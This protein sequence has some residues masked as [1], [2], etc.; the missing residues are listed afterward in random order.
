MCH[1]QKWQLWFSYFLSYLPFSCFNLHLC[2]LCNMNTLQNILMILGN[3]VEQGKKT[4]CI[5]EWQLWPFYF[6]SYLPFLCLNLILCSLRWVFFELSPFVLCFKLI[7]CPLCYSNIL[8]NM[9]MIL[10]RKVEQDETTCHLQEWQLWRG[11]GGH[12]FF[13]F[14]K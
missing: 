10:S 6:W 2:L 13:F 9:L 4:C 12:L 7:L 8:H 11:F 1:I 14:S 3:N 5:Q